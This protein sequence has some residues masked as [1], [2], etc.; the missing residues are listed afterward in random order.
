MKLVARR[1]SAEAV[2]RFGA[3]VLA[4]S[5]EPTSESAAYRFWSDLAHFRVEGETEI[6]I[7]TVF[8][9]P[10]V[11][12]A[13]LERHARTPEILVPIDAP[14]AVPLM[15]DG[16]AGV[17][18]FQV[19]LGEALVIDPMV[20]HAGPVPVGQAR[21]SYFVIFRRGTPHEDVEKRPVPP[22]EVEAV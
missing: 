3:V 15:R 7:C 22:V 10:G 17:S 16:D 18:V 8:A 1:A 19:E 13:S 21:S 12:I 4:P 20:W 14:F 2:A 11:P 6:G 9:R 5:G